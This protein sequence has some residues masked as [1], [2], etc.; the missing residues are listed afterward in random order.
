MFTR[1]VSVFMENKVG[2]IGEITAIL[3]EAGIDIRAFCISDTTEFGI[4]RL[5]VRSPE[6]AAELLRAAGMTAQLS[7]VVV[8]SINDKVG[9]L[10]EIAECLSE[11]GINIQYMYSF[12][13][14]K[15]SRGHVALFSSNLEKLAETLQNAGYEP[16]KIEQ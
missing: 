15:L 1:Q 7:D 11:N 14:E 8:V 4:L 6:R 5:I 10:A 2:K 16:Q 3:N 9:S 12:M 13:S